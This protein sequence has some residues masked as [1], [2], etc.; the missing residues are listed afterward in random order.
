[1][2]PKKLSPFPLFIIGI[3][4][5]VLFGIIAWGMHVEIGWIVAFDLTWIERIQSFISEG[6]TSLI[7]RITELGNVRL[8]IVLTILLVIVL[9]FKRKYAEGLW[10]GGTILFCA[11]IATKILKVTFDRDRPDILQLISKTNESF[12]S[13]HATAT[14]IFYGL[15]GLVIV[16]A[17][18]A[19]WKK[20]IVSF[21][22]LAWIIFILVSRVYLGVHFPTDVI[23]GFLFGM[24]SIFISI[25]VYLVALDPLR[26]LLGKL[27][28]ND[29]SE[30]FTRRLK[31]H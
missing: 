29:Q 8:I 16:L 15:I 24:A 5:L 7:M 9:F 22:T 1:M 18:S 27:K 19:L 13:G 4:A 26:E 25:A 17:T 2:K 14:T 28:L 10:L 31:Q 20:C 6:R 3:L 21:I 11:A 23:G 12:P 30:T